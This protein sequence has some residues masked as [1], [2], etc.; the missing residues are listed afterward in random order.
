MKQ[1]TSRPEL[2][3]LRAPRLY[4]Q[5]AE[6][7]YS[8]IKR[9]HLRP[10]DLIPPER[11]LALQLGISRN[12]VREALV[13]LEMMGVIA[14][15]RSTGAVVQS[16]AFPSVTERAVMPDSDPQ[17]LVNNLIE[18][19]LILEPEAA[20]MAAA[21][22]TPE[23][24]DRLRSILSRAAS[25]LNDIELQIQCDAEF[26]LALSVAS[27]NDVLVRI[28]ASIGDLFEVSRRWTLAVEGRAHTSLEQHRKVLRAVEDK[29][30]EA[31]RAHMHEHISSVVRLRAAV[32]AE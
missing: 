9:Q 6:Q 25:N 11:E 26:H 29:D 5:A 7:I 4:M 31:A 14:I 21:R 24:I 32:L 28:M 8:L 22:R 1:Q 18:I 20:A 10:G 2:T 13:A 30:V 3:K 16:L 27:G 12:S 23:D 19:R 17:A 15:K